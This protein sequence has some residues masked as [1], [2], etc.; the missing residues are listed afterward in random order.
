MRRSLLIVC[1]VGLLLRAAP[2]S[3]CSCMRVGTPFDE[4][5][6]ASAVFQGEII[7]VE[8]E[9]SATLATARLLYCAAARLLDLQL[10][11][12]CF[13]PRD[14]FIATFRVS[15]AWKGVPEP[16]VRVL[17]ARSGGGS[18][19]LFWQV[20]EKWVVYAY[21]IDRLQANLC[22]RSSSGVEGVAESEALGTPRSVFE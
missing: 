10:I 22:S 19:G 2:A 7:A 17:S 13:M 3:A 12:E 20:G 21:G 8:S 14:G 6:K 9:E 16:T 5:A 11:D 18:C 4:L 1:L 15:A